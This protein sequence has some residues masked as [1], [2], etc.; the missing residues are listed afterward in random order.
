MKN[1]QRE[2]SG[3]NAVASAHSRSCP[4]WMLKKLKVRMIH[5]DTATK[6]LKIY[7]LPLE[8]RSLLNS[9]GKLFAPLECVYTYWPEKCSVYTRWNRKIG[10]PE[11]KGKSLLM[12]GYLKKNFRLYQSMI[13]K[14]DL[15][16]QV[17]RIIS[18]EIRFYK[19]HKKFCEEI[20][21]A[22]SISEVL[23]KCKNI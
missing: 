2:W 1:L 12:K 19:G 6:N 23:E 5:A 14:L 4:H 11:L 7:P 3:I 8:E 9:M 21:A 10:F 20:I 15:R 17:Y 16:N 22:Q 18:R 13:S